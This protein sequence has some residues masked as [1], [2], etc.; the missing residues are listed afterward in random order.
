MAIFS[1][2]NKDLAFHREIRSSL[3]VVFGLGASTICWFLS[4]F[5]IAFPFSSSFLNTYFLS[6]LMG[7]LNFTLRSE[8]KI[9]RAMDVR[10]KLL[11]DLGNWRGKRHSLFLPTRGQRSRTNGRTQK[12]SRFNSQ[13]S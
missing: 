2:R 5:G 1:F 10:I 9:R 11:K 8:T 4:R 3:K 13:L 12:R 7:F 6:N